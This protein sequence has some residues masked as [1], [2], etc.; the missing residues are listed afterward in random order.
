MVMIK[1]KEKNNFKIDIEEMTK[2]G[3]HFGHKTSKIHPKM[4]EYLLGVRN[5]IHIIDLEKTKE[6]LEDTLEFIQKLILEDKTLLIVG[7]K[8]QVKNLVKKMAEDCELPY[9]SERW[10]GGTFTHFEEIKKRTGYFKDLERKKA[11]GELEK[12]T[13][14]ERVEIDKEIQRLKVKFEGI[15]N[16]EKLPEAVLLLSMKEDDLAMKEARKKGIKIIAICDTNCNPDLADFIIPAND[17]S[18]SS[19]KYIL[20]K[21]AA[22]IKKAKKKK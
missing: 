17:D 7:T 10:I 3:L 16:L 15:K 14:K 13:K 20:D 5:T 6:K 21:V 19:L 11:Q 9:V 8:I 4:K 2:A 12:Y 18:I 22:V 1:D